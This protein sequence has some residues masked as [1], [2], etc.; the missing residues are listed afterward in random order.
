MRRSLFRLTPYALRLTALCLTHVALVPPSDEYQDTREALVER[1]D[2]V[3]LAAGLKAVRLSATLS[4]VAQK[5]AEEISAGRS[6]KDAAQEDMRR[7][8]NAGYT[9]RFISEV[10]AQADGDVESVV[11]AWQEEGSETA[12]ELLGA[13]Y[14]EVG[15]GVGRS[16]DVPVYVFLFALSWEDFFREKTAALSD[17]DRVRQEMLER[18]N[19][20]R[21][22]VRLPPFRRHPRL[23]DAAQAHAND[24]LARRYY[25]HD[26]PEGRTVMDREQARGYPATQAGENIAR[27]Q[28]SVEEVMDGW[29]GSPIHREHLLSPV[30]NEIGFGLAFGK[31]ASG[32]TILWVQDFGRI[33]RRGRR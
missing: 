15:V 6:G 16:E 19:R 8:A 22:A 17:L 20:E 5:R 23:D 7:A 1:I 26:T 29:M 11:N 32:Y 14:R 10:E 21:A 4:A 3:R 33:F 9:A 28:F 13:D 27:G 30:L 18:V 24:M 31:T 25:A 12:R 2:A